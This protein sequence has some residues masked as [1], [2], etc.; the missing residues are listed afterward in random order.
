MVLEIIIAG[1]VGI[2]GTLAGI[3]ITNL[4]ER[5]RERSRSKLEEWKMIV[6]EVYSP[7][8]FDLLNFQK[9]VLLRLKAID[10][11]ISSS[12]GKFTG[13]AMADSLTL[14]A[15]MTAKIKQSHV[16]ED[17]LRKNSRLIRPS[18][19]WLDL[20][21]F[22]AYLDEIEEIFDIIAVGRFKGSPDN[23]FTA[24]Q[25]CIEIGK[26]LEQAASH[27]RIFIGKLVVSTEEMP[28]SLAYT[29][30]FTEKVIEKLEE[31]HENLLRVLSR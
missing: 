21:L 16:L 27:I 20:Y 28:K 11:T 2:V 1:V 29:P 10:A 19:L 15:S 31:R 4:L 25:N 18:T 6:D 30:F 3:I 9:G 5:Q 7:M 14:L 22:Q 12:T 26:E 13:K 24:I 17:I 23:L 8:I